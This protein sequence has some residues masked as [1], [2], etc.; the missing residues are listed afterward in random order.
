MSGRVNLTKKV[1]TEAGRRFCPVVIAPNGRVKPDWVIVNGTSEKHEEGHYYIEWREDGARRRKSVGNSASQAAARQARKEFELTAVDQG[2]A[3]VP[4]ETQE[5]R[6]TVKA[7]VSMYLEEIELSKKPKTLSAYSLALQYFTE[8]CHKVYVED[9]ERIDMLRYAAFLREK[10]A[11]APR[12]V[13]NKFADV[14]TFLKSQEIVGLVK[15]GDWPKF[16]QSD[17]ETYEPEELDLFFAICHPD[18]RL[19]FEFFLMT[20][21]REQEVIFCTWRDVNAARG[22]VSMRWKPEY[23]WTPKNYKER[24]IPVPTKLIAALEK[25]RPT[26]A[27]GLLFPTA[28]GK[29]KHDFLDACKAVAKRSE[30]NPDDWWLHKFRATF[31]TMHL[32]AGVDLRTVQAWM[33]HVDLESTLRYLKPARSEQARDQVNATFAAV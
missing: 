32:R 2:V 19:W 22:T 9:I 29:P 7:A 15:K 27:R 24:E 28:S 33:G 1:I 20:G 23:S 25:V 18:E 17:V 8:S 5:R 26:E 31:A 6:R 21:M 14:M 11:Q 13:R 10:K 30:L 4:E 16:V 3:V 12:S